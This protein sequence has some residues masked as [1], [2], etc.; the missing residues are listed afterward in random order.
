MRV[1]LKK[2][3]AL[4]VLGMGMLFAVPWQIAESLAA[5]APAAKS[6]RFDPNDIDC[7][8]LEA[9]HPRLRIIAERR[10]K[11]QQANFTIANTENIAEE[12]TPED[13]YKGDDKE[14]LEKLVRKVW[15]ARYP[16]DS[17]VAIRFPMKKWRR[18]KFWKDIDAS[19]T[20]DDTILLEVSVVIL[21]DPDVATIFPAFLKKNT[22]KE[23]IIVGVDTKKPNYSIKQ[24]LMKN[25]KP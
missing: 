2:G 3:I 5:E 9:L 24:M 12:T 13:L 25:W 20:K 10:C 16:Q 21:S 7:G 8:N 19:D 1:E 14:E 4:L 17:I 11:N 15:K 23:K 18:E 6:G 22:K